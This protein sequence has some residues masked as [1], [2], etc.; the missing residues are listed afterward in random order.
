MPCRCHVVAGLVL[1][2]VGA[3]G[4]QF[5]A[6]QDATA[7]PPLDPATAAQVSYRQDVWPIV[8]RHCWSCHS[9]DE[10]G[11]KLSMD[12]AAAL[13]A[14]GESGAAVVPGAPD[15]SL[16]VRMLS[17][18][19]QPA[20]PRDEPPL[21]AAK[22][23]VLR[24]WILAGAVDDTVSAAADVAEPV[25]PEWYAFPPAIAAL[26]FSPDGRRLV[27]A[28]RGEVV[29]VDPLGDTPGRRLA[30]DGDLVTW[31]EFSPDGALLAVAG[32]TP[33]SFGEV[34][35]YGG[36]DGAP[37]WSRRLG[38]DTLFRGGFSPDGALLALGSAD[39]GIYLLASDGA[40]EPRKADLHSDWVTDVCF[41][42]DGRLLISSGRD[43]TVKVSLVDGGKLI[44]S[45]ASSSGLFA[46]VAATPTLALAGGRDRVPAAYDLRAALGDVEFT[47][48]AV[49]G[50]A[51]PIEQAAQF[52]RA[53]EGQSGEILDLALSGD[54]SLLA[55]AS[56]GGEVRVYRVADG[57][58]VAAIG[59][60]PSPVYSV[61][62]SGDGTR[63]AAGSYNGEINLVELP[64]GTRLKT[65]VP[66]PVRL[67]GP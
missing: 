2:S 46:A 30:T 16:L 44:R 10:A 27:A 63:L 48:R 24:Q 9:G 60:L 26:A 21:P 54:R 1:L 7:L 14:G 12:S 4:A 56:S 45:L 32:G 22:I 42:A 53:F 61:A 41:S 35:V 38:R 43:K 50:A 20:M 59:G 52:T 58:L 37:R 40:G 13:V 57:G 28:C 55:V 3:A 62:L 11:G 8:K 19:A 31:V 15:E 6:A 25:L 39:G 49:E 66:V 47:G 65:V 64:S 33:A 34:R 67:A 5:V 17:G 36:A 18:A 51:P 23:Q 29:F